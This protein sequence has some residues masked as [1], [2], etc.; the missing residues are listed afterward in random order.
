MVSHINLCAK[1][2]KCTTSFHTE[3]SCHLVSA[4]AASGEYAA[5]S[6]NS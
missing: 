4:H 2:T 1:F 6:A 3:Q 5:A